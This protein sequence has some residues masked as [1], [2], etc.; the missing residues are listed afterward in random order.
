MASRH[1]KQPGNAHRDQNCVLH[2]DSSPSNNYRTK[3]QLTRYPASKKDQFR[4][5][6]IKA[7]AV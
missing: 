1:R 2:S 5:Y 3:V 6:F 7:P 4:L